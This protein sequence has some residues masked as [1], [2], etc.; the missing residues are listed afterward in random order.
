MLTECRYL[1]IKTCG[2]IH[3]SEPSSKQKKGASEKADTCISQKR[4]ASKFAYAFFQ[5][6]ECED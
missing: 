4:A 5:I 3:L 6:W 2:V 1:C